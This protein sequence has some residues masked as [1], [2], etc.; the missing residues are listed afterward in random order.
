[1]DNSSVAPAGPIRVSLWR[2]GLENFRRNWRA[3]LPVAGLF[4][5]LALIV[6]AILL[7]G[8]APLQPQIEAMKGQK[9]P[10]ILMP[11]LLSISPRVFSLTLLMFLGMFAQRYVFLSFFLEKEFPSQTETASVRQ[12]FCFLSKSVQLIF[13]VAVPGLLICLIPAMTLAAFHVE[14]MP[15]II[16]S[17]VIGWAL[18]IF[19]GVRLTLTLPLSAGNIAAPLKTSWEMTRSNVWRLIGN[20]L[21]IIGV[22]IGCYL[23][24]MLVIFALGFGV[25][26]IAKNINGAAVDF[27]SPF[28]RYAAGS[29]FQVFSGGIACAYST[30]VCQILYNEK[31]AA[32]PAFVL[33]KRT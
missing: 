27:I 16:V 28:I 24:Y 11:F 10:Q 6:N 20:L 19:L 31:K 2:E 29:A 33:T 4:F 15:A 8:M 18:M 25:E 14:A 7:H 12:F 9:D 26:A 32:D 3:W 1:M 13:C 23:L 17:V 5:L 30:A 22:L 21:M